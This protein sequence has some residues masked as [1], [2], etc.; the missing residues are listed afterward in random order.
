MPTSAHAACTVLTEIYGGFAISQRADVGIGPYRGH[1]NYQLLRFCRNQ[2]R[3]PDSGGRAVCLF[4]ARIQALD[5][6]LGKA[7][8]PGPAGDGVGHYGVKCVQR[9]DVDK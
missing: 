4:C 8:K 6:M 3:P 9:G 2:T 7:V 5:M 1:I